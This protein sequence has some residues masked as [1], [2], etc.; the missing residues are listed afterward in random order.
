MGAPVGDLYYRT[1]EL[2]W[3]AFIGWVSVAFLMLNLLFGMAYA[4]LPGAIVNMPPRSIVYGFFFSIETLGT[5]GYGN[6]APMT[7]A[8]HIVAGLEILTGLFFSATM[9]GLIFARFA[10]PRTSL[11]FSRYAV[12]G[13][14]DGKPALMVRMA[15]TRRHPLADASAQMAWLK[16][17]DLPGGGVMRRLVDLPLVRSHNAM[18]GLAWTLTHVIEDDSEFLAALTGTQTFSLTVAV[19]PRHLARHAVSRRPIL[20]ARGH[21]DRS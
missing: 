8:G 3:P 5:V 4:L 6:M 2:S 16:R 13:R 11:I 12:I 7:P 10:R 15:S 18:L 17:T 1:M 19:R 9:T 21:I 14:F 20:S